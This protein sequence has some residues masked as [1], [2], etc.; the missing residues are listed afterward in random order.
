[1]VISINDRLWKIS[2]VRADSPYLARS[3]GGYTI[4]CTDNKMQSLFLSEALNGDMLKKVLCHE[5]VHCFSFSYHLD[6]PL[7]AEEIIADFLATYG[8]DVFSVADS[9]MREIVKAA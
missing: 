6:I 9:V 8:Q 7:E 5:L 2:F 4:G 3:D 1:M